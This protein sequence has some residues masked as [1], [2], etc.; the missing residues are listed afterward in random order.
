MV[1]L[2][3]KKKIS[4]NDNIMGKIKFKKTNGVFDLLTSREIQI[5][6]AIL[7]EKR[8]YE[9]A[10]LF[11]IKHNTISTFKK[12]IFNKLNVH[13]EIGLYKLAI[14]EGVVKI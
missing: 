13:S 14:K 9:I 6:E 5:V 10:N 2:F 12:S 11:A 1:H 7:N 3:Q 4:G 8:G